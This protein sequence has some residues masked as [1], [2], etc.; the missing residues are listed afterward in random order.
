M[1]ARLATP[2]G[3]SRLLLYSSTKPCSRVRDA[4]VLTAAATSHAS[5]ADSS[6]ASLFFL[7]LSTTVCIML[8]PVNR[9]VGKQA[10]RQGLAHW[11]DGFSVGAH[12]W[13]RGRVSK[14]RRAQ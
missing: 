6:C 14:Q 11:K 8:H 3:P 1:A 9:R 7:S 4:T 13:R 5:R 2:N 10:R 12:Q